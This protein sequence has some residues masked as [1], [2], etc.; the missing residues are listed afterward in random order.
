MASSSIEDNIIKSLTDDNNSTPVVNTSVAFADPS[1]SSSSNTTSKDGQFPLHLIP[2]IP[3]EP[4]YKGGL[5]Y[6]KLS[7][8]DKKNLQPL[9]FNGKTTTEIALYRDNLT[10]TLTHYQNVCYDYHT[11]LRRQHSPIASSSLPPT[12]GKKKQK[13]RATD[14]DFNIKQLQILEETMDESG[15]HLALTVRHNKLYEPE[16]VTHQAPRQLKRS[17]T[18]NFNLDLHYNLHMRKRFH[19]FTEDSALVTNFCSN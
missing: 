16:Y 7:K 12:K 17:A 1:G 11:Y 15:L 4:I 13:G 14:P 10:I 3:D 19:H 6:S 18:R 5:T 9:K 8:K 2:F